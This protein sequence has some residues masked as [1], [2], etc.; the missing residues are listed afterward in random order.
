MSN[1]ELIDMLDKT[2]PDTLSGIENEKDLI[3]AKARMDVVNFVK[4]QFESKPKK[5]SK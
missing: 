3:I 1:V 5:R 4:M 2:Y